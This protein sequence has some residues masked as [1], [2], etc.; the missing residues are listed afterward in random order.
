MIRTPAYAALDA[1]S[2]LAPF[3]IER[4]EPGP[5]EVLID[6]LYCGVCHSDIHQSRDGWGGSIFPM[7]PGSRRNSAS[8]WRIPPPACA[9]R[10]PRG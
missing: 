1:T 5:R 7:V 3:A 9:P 2:P 6:I 10:S 8:C 4:R